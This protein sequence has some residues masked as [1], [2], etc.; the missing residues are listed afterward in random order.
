MTEGGPASKTSTSETMHARSRVWRIPCFAAPLAF[1]ALL[2]APA[3]HAWFQQDDFAWLYMSRWMPEGSG[4]FYKLFSPQAQGTIRPLGERIPFLLLMNVFGRNAA[5][6]HLLALTTQLANVLL[7]ANI[8]SRLLSSSAG[9]TIAALLWSAGAALATPLV[10][11]S[12][13]N[14]VLFAFFLLSAF[15]FHLLYEDTSRRHFLA[16]EWIAFLL[17]FGAQELNVVYPALVLVWMVLSGNRRWKSVTL[18]FGVAA[19]YAAFRLM[20]IPAASGPYALSFGTESFRTLWRYWTI[21]LGPEEFVRHFGALPAPYLWTALLSALALTFAVFCKSPNEKWGRD[22]NFVVR[23]PLASTPPWRNWL[24]VPIFQPPP[25]GV[26]V[27]LFGLLWFVVSIAP[28]LLIPNQ[29]QTY[30]LFVPS[31]GLAI[32]GAAAARFAASPGRTVKFITA[33]ALVVVFA[34]NLRTAIADRNWTIDRTLKVEH[35]YDAIAEVRTTRPASCILLSGIDDD[36]FWAGYY[37]VR[38]YVP[39]LEETYLAPGASRV[40]TPIL[41]IFGT[42]ADYEMP[43]DQARANLASGRCVAYDVAAEK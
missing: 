26:R 33:I 35:L 19:A 38:R 25:H 24:S 29:V 16:L 13:Y 9:G 14:Q 23:S 43:E 10:W 28:V 15:L 6:F 37:G 27:G 20:Y 41:T 12:A 30:Y 22:T 39:D 11:A 32:L 34:T 7:V 4:L 2:Y 1:V 42:P 3:L 21:A 18:Q 5:V 40:I 8:G 36:A 17:G 31:I